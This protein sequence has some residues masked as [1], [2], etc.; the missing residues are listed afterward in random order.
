MLPTPNTPEA[1]NPT[2]ASCL[3]ETPAV[4]YDAAVAPNIHYRT[5][6][7]LSATERACLGIA[8]THLSRGEPQLVQVTVSMNAVSSALRVG[9][10]TNSRS[11]WSGFD[12][13]KL[14]AD[15][16]G[17]IGSVPPA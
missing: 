16:I 12:G 2:L 13:S 9:E 7:T 6:G 11:N 17:R 8:A 1:T 4:M 15:G 10:S 5:T 14:T 3:M